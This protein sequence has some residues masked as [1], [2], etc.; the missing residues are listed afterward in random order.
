MKQSK[1]HFTVRLL[2]YF[3]EDLEKLYELMPYLKVVTMRYREEQ[4]DKSIAIA[5]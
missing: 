2:A 5:G 4:N 1:V 3:Y